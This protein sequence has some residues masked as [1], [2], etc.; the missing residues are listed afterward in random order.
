MPSKSLLDEIIETEDDDCIDMH[1]SLF[2]DTNVV[3]DNV[4]DNLVE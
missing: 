4:F 3:D 2:I 1:G